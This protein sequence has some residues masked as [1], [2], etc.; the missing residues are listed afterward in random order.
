MASLIWPLQL[1]VPV[2]DSQVK[3]KS[4][5]SGDYNDRFQTHRCKWV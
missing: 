3:N 5:L 2:R 4:M 1:S